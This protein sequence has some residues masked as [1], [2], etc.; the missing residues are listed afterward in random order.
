MTTRVGV[1]T[2]RSKNPIQ[3]AKEAVAGALKNAGTTSCD[4]VMMF[5]TVGYDQQ[6]LV[7]TVRE[8]TAK[9]PLAGC[10]GEGVIALGLGDEGTHAVSVM[11]WQSDELK[12]RHVKAK[13][14]K[15]DGAAV[16]RAVGAAIGE[17][18]ADALGL[19]TFADGLTFNFDRFSAGFQAA[20]PTT[21][22]L[23][24]IGGTAGDNYTQTR[25]YQYFDDEV[26]SDGVTC[27]LLSGPG[28]L[29]VDVSHGCSIIGAERTI[30]KSEGNVIQEIDGKPALDVM[31]EYLSVDEIKDHSLSMISLC[32]GFKAPSEIQK[33]Y[34]EYIIRVIAGRDDAKKTIS[35]YT[36][37]TPGTKV[38]MT[39]RDPDKMLQGIDQMT[40]RL[41][42]KLGGKKPQAVFQV[43]C[44]GRGK[45]MFREEEKG[46][47]L[48]RLQER[49]GTAPW[50]GFYAY[51]EIAPVGA[52]T[53]FHNYTSVIAAVG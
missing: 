41:S 27:A 25:T 46:R 44:M 39:R 7:S 23:P 21:K 15:D 8:E 1:G 5:A 29:H 22:Q 20:R 52:S 53:Y 6:Q 47:F 45:H 3:A 4:F 51:G 16:G 26:F 42:E 24:I 40:Q 10:S 48:A 31:A 2:S 37:V 14:L 36:D 11:V 33:G 32:L 28:A 12:F 13:G 50:I 49:V 35:I 18:P 34:D 9:A 30:T 43:E 38:W 19:F 17:I